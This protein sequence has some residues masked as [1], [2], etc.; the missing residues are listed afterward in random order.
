MG[1]LK[2]VGIGEWL[3]SNNQEDIIRTYALGSC[4]AL[5]VQHP[6]TRTSGLV[7]IAL[8]ETITRAT[9]AVRSDGYYADTAVPAFLE[10]IRIKAGLY[11]TMT[12]G[13][14]AKLAGGA[15]MMQIKNDYQIGK[16][17]VQ[18]IQTILQRYQVPVVAM[19]V[20]GTLSRTVSVSVAGGETF[21]ASPGQKERIL[22]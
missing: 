19:D 11:S 14:T 5:V 7:H 9:G 15:Q 6:A 17:I 13:M 22:K 10:A 20:G 12:G 21:V 3:V 16:R 18:T 8:P 1:N 4:V 2:V